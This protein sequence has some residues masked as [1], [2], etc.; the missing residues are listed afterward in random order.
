LP[1]RRVTTPP[2]RS[3]RTFSPLPPTS[4]R[5]ARRVGGLFLWH[6][7]AGF[8]GSDFPTT[9][10]CGVR[11]FLERRL[12][13][14]RPRLPGRQWRSLGQSRATVHAMP[15]AGGAGHAPPAHW[16]FGRFVGVQALPYA[17]E[18]ALERRPATERPL[19]GRFRVARSLL[20]ACEPSRAAV[21]G[22]SPAEQAS[23]PASLARGVLGGRESELSRAHET[24]LITPTTFPRIST[25]RLMIG[26]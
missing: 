19:H 3:Y 20:L 25:S 5:E 22:R 9:P 23:L 12:S 2:V 7:P 15:A 8:P 17:R 18:R 24:L 21:L 13:L 1:G 16:T 6:F 26:S 11:T 14:R 10:P 4:S